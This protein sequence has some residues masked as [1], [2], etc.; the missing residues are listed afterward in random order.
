[1]NFCV[2]V[3]PSASAGGEAVDHASFALGSPRATGAVRA[4]RTYTQDLHAIYEAGNRRPRQA[5]MLV[6]SGWIRL[7]LELGDASPARTFQWL[8]SACGLRCGFAAGSAR[9][10]PDRPSR[11]YCG[12]DSGFDS[13]SC[14][15]RSEV[16]P[17]RP[18]RN[19]RIHLPSRSE[20]SSGSSQKSINHRKAGT[21]AK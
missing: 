20:A 1:M 8:Q 2:C 5:R 6:R 15:V 11:T 13:D 18:R 9:W 10:H 12:F 4:R 3:P 21:K 7:T 16:C 19:A 14:S 17:D